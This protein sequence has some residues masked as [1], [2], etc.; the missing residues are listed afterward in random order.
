MATAGP[1]NPSTN[2]EDT[3]IG[4]STINNKSNAYVQDDVYAT[5]S[6]TGTSYYAVYTGFGITSADVPNTA[7]IN[8]ILFEIRAKRTATNA[9]NLNSIKAVKANSIVGSEKGSFALTTTAAYYSA[10]GSADLHGTT[11][12][13]SDVQNSGF[14]VAIALSGTAMGQGSIDHVRVT[15]T[16]TPVAG[17]ATVFKTKKIDLFNS[18]ILGGNIIR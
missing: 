11:W 3:S 15:I 1:F 12:S 8:G 9:G 7:T 10:G 5:M 13:P 4:A 16:Y 14:G 18:R 6:A 2:A 17:G